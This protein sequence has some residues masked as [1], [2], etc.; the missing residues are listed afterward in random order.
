MG[1]AR[2]AVAGSLHGRERQDAQHRLLRHPGGGR[3]RC[4]RGHPQRGP[5]REA[6]NEPRRRDGRAGGG[7]AICGDCSAVVAPDRPAPSATTSK[8]WGVG[9]DKRA[10]VEGLL[11][12]RERQAARSASTTHRRTPR[13]TTPRSGVRASKAAARRTRSLTGNWCRSRH[14][15]RRR[16]SAAATSRP[17][18]SR[19][20]APAAAARPR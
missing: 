2:A 18:P 11:Q 16:A 4:Q 20:R 17:P 15:S 5:R 8:F 9:W 13:A 3:A 10:T 7:L 12:G 1:Q 6:A 19:H 14:G